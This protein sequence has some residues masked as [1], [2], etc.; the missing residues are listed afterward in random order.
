MI[1]SGATA[2]FVSQRFVE[3]HQLLMIPLERNI[4]LHNIDGSKNK[5]GQITHRARI[6]MKIGSY[7][8]TSDFFVTDIGP[9]DVI[10]AA[11]VAWEVY[12]ERR[13]KSVIMPMSLWTKPGTKMAPMVAVVFLAWY[14]PPPLTRARAVSMYELTR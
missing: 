12:R 5:A 3:R 2:C 1:D 9:E 10:L 8:E 4:A 11:F 13:D 14:V 7:S 6:G